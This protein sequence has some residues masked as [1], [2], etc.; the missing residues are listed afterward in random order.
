MRSDRPFRTG[1]P[2]VSGRS[3][4][5]SLL[6]PIAVLAACGPS[7]AHRDAIRSKTAG[8]TVADT[9]DGFATGISTSEARFAGNITGFREPE[10]VRYDPDQDVFFVSNM[11]GLGSL[12]DGNGFIS[13][14][15][16]ANPED[17]RPLVQGGKNGA[18]LDAPKGMAL[19]GDTLWVADIDKLRGFD[20]HNGAPLATIDFA[21]QHAVL[22]NDVAVG[23]DG[24]VR[25]TDTGILMNEAG[26]VHVGPDRIFDV[27][28][29]GAITVVAQGPQLHWPNGITW[30]AGKKQ[31][32]VVSFD[33]FGGEVATM[34]PND[35]ARHVIRNGKGNLDGVEVL[36]NE[37]IM[38]SSWADSSIHVIEQGKER[39]IIRHVPVP[40]D[41]GYDT[42]RNRVAIPLSTLGWVQLWD[43]GPIGRPAR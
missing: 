8:G 5:L 4:L 19:H 9:V 6:S 3:A 40:A 22:L 37:A 2:P 38:F 33:P 32:I 18:V 31:W 39:Q 21:P 34:A 15:S 17:A 35:S 28:P 30:D 42:R 7:D 26:A 23:G 36:P 16:A 43:L 14:V 10:S 11:F 41:I 24:H 12:K 27:G 25:V 1:W 29:G 13:K 20:R